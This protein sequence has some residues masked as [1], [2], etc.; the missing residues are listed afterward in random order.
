MSF[1]KELFKNMK[2][3]VEN[4]YTVY[5]IIYC[6]KD[7]SDINIEVVNTETYMYYTIGII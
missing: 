3:Y 2:I 7:K 6:V 1:R 5:M 4:T